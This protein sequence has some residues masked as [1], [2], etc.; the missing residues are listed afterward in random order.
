MLCPT[1]WTVR[2]AS[3]QSVL[4]NHEVL[5]G[6]WEESKAS[7]IDS[8]IRARIIG[9]ER[10]R[11]PFWIIACFTVV[12]HSDNLSKG[13]QHNLCLQLKVSTLLN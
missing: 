10:L 8:E 6:V 13:L 7:S 1:R 3:I 9:V 4:D 5:V 11:L 12:R 2:A